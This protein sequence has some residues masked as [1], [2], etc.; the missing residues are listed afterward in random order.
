MGR[1]SRQS[2]GGVFSGNSV[3][4]LV[5]STLAQLAVAP[6]DFAARTKPEVSLSR[7]VT[8]RAGSLPPLLPVPGQGIGQGSPL[9]P[10][11]GVTDH[12]RWL[13]DDNQHLVL[14]NDVQGNGLRGQGLQMFLQLNLDAISSLQAADQQGGHSIDQHRPR[15]LFQADQL[16]A[17]EA[18]SLTQDLPQPGPC[19]LGRHRPIDISLPAPP[20]P[21]YCNIFNHH[22]IKREPVYRFVFLLG[23]YERKSNFQGKAPSAVT[24]FIVIT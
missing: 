7:R 19:L 13:V 6:A 1:A 2:E 10:L 16:P 15:I 11:S 22:V 4:Y 14:I 18:I 17:G 23:S 24:Q 21:A 8:R 3:V 9:I 12:P 20:F 5:Y